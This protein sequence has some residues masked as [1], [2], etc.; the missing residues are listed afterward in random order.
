IWIELEYAEHFRICD[1]INQHM[2]VRN[3]RRAGRVLKQMSLISVFSFILSCF[4][5]EQLFDLGKP[6]SHTRHC[7]HYGSFSLLSVHG[8]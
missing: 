5:G 6:A 2:L 1:R 8:Y 4:P 7:R 3:S